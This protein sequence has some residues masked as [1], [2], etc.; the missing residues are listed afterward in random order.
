MLRTKA[1]TYAVLAI[2]EIARRHTKKNMGVQASEIAGYLGLPGAYAAKVLT[3]LARANILRSDRG[4]RGGFRMAKP[5][6]EIDLLQVIEAV[7]GRIGSGGDFVN[8]PESSGLT[9]QALCKVFKDI[10]ESVRTAL[11]QKTVADLMP[12]E[13]LA[14]SSSE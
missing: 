2:A 14:A 6:E 3:Q 9:G 5:V 8:D 13:L 12:S 7:D 1:S 4:P 10:I 11:R